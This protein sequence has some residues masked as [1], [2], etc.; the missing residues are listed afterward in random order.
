MPGWVESVELLLV[1]QLPSFEASDHFPSD[2]RGV[3]DFVS[4]HVPL[5]DCGTFELGVHRARR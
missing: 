5:S 2:C 4:Q 1:H 3:G